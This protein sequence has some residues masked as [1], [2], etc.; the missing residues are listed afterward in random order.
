MKQRG[1]FEKDPGSGIWWIRYADQ[2]GRI[3]R[4]KI[5]PKR[6]AISA[7]QKRK[8]EVREGR[9][10]PEKFKR[11]AISFAEIA[12]D[13]L[14][15][16]RLNKSQGSFKADRWHMPTLLSWFGDRPAAEITPQDIEQRLGGLI[17]KGFA[18]ATFNRYRALLSLLY[19]VAV[20]NGK[21]SDNP[22]R[23]VRLRKENNARV[24]FLDQPEETTLR[25]VIQSRF[26]E[27]EP[28][29]DLALHT[30]MR[31]GEQHRLRWEDVDIR[32]GFITIPR[33]RPGDRRH[34]PVN[35]VAHKA[36][37]SLWKRRDESGFVCPGPVQLRERNWERWFEEA[38]NLAGISN[39][40]WHDIRHTFA[41]RLVMAGVDLRTVQELLGHKT[42]AMTVRYSHLAPAHQRD[43][44][45]RLTE[46]PT[47]TATSTGP[48]WD[49]QDQSGKTSQVQ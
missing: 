28:E 24:R 35:S 25:T 48:F 32:L 10:F 31:R 47:G 7:Y 20:R 4:E 38:V 3:R 12:R 19:S 30:G 44:V 45:E 49:S 34:I 17:E 29:F 16:S 27:R 46:Q 13:A 8:T 6:L 11:R 9:F 1:I 5:G 36:L 14:E 22:A 18:P 23:L 43:A 40:H 42:I 39:F 41:S 33:S 26:S 15:Y 2:L 37:E 21:I